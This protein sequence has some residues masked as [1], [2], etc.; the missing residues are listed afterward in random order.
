MLSLSGEVLFSASGW[1]CF[2][3]RTESRSSWKFVL[4]KTT[5]KRDWK[6]DI[7]NNSFPN[8]LLILQLKLPQLRI[9]VAAS[10]RQL[11]V[12]DFL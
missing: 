9:W 6:T 4:E 10:A 7:L 3:I 5:E 2:S 1:N 8:L 12:A 11:F